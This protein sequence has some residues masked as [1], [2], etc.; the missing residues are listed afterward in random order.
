[1]A[2]RMMQPPRQILATSSML[3]SYPYSLEATLIR[4][5]PWA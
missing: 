4:A 2:A 3:M 1:M 5:R